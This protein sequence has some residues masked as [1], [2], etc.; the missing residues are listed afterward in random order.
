MSRTSK[1]VAGALGLL[2]LAPVALM[3]R[4]VH[5]LPSEWWLE[6]AYPYALAVGIIL[7]AVWIIRGLG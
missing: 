7:P 3:S 2:V 1:W 5:F 6:S 4:Y